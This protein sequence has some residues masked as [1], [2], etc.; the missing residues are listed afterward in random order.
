[1]SKKFEQLNKETH[2][3]LKLKI[4]TDFS[5]L[6]KQHIAPVVMHEFYS[7]ATD[8]PIVFVKNEELG[9]EF[10]AVAMLG[11]KSDENLLIE[12]KKWIG[13]Y[14]PASYTHYPLSLIP[15]PDDS[16]QYMINIF[17]DSEA[18][19]EKEGEAIFNQDGSETEFF[20]QKRQALENFYM[21]ARGTVDFVKAITKLDLLEELTINFTIGDEKRAVTGVHA[22]NQE[23]FHNL[24][25]KD[26][27]E[28][29]EKG[30]LNLIYAHFVSMNQIQRLIN[31]ISA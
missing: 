10:M 6:A 11:L 13:Y 4:N 19:S 3:N 24:S 25:D 9:D 2:K 28:L 17:M 16:K 23:K 27:N 18:I 7:V 29:K 1:M 5:H 20:N 8:L 12:G 22:I 31:R 14:M 30:Y 21:S 15:N 26:F